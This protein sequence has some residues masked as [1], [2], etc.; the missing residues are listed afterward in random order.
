MYSVLKRLVVGTPL[1]TSEEQHQRLGKPTALAVFASDAISS[2]AYATEE[3]LLVLVPIAGMAALENLIP[4]ALVVTVIL[5]IV[6]TSYR[7]VIHAYPDGGGSYVVSKDNL[8]TTPALVAGAS[9]MVDYVL[10]VAV[11]VSAGTA[12]IVSAFPDLRPHRVTLCLFFV[13]LMTFANLR[14]LKEAGRTFAVPTYVYVVALGC[15]V[16]YGLYRSFFGDLGALPVNQADLEELTEGH[17]VHAASLFLL[18]RAFSSGAVALSGVEAISNGV[19]AFRPPE[20]K[21]AA[22]TLVYMAMILGT[23]FFGIS[24]LAHRLQPTVSEDETLLSIMGAGVFGDGSFL[25]YLLQFSTFGILILAA[26]TAYSGFPLLSSIVA[27]D[28]FLP[29]QLA[30]R[31]DRLVYSNGILVLAG[32]AALLIIVFQGETTLLIPLYAVGVFT[33]FTLSQVGMVRRHV[34]RKE[35]RW[36][37]SVAING[38]GAVATFI[39]LLV[40]VVSKFT[41]GAWIPAVV[42]PAIVV[43]LR[44]VGRHY[45][46]VNEA[47]RPPPNWRP[48]RRTHTVVMPVGRIHAGV[49][50]AIE[51]ARSLA[52]DRLLAVTVASDEEQHEAINAEWRHFDIPVELRVLYSPYRDLTD[53]IMDFLDEISEQNPDDYMTVIVPEF[54]VDHWWEQLLHNQSALALKARLLFRPKTIVVS[55]PFHLG[56]QPAER[57]VDG[58]G[59]R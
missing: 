43:V 21:H 45:D 50:E 25:Y 7:Q 19:P 23:F 55:V 56:R 44:A 15:L 33:G 18:L 2:T 31:G 17:V 47:L 16:G 27:R 9:L 24:V 52:P 57:G 46:R 51:Y 35:P 54:V 26:N 3:I 13:A 36:Q 48:P 30:N 5:A 38:V 14:G 6:A 37:R 49:L 4:I 32:A 34:A 39:V 28:G 11:S 58:R 53:P 20:S 1:A 40:V 42:I 22:Q 8:G 41:I 10:T 59:G 29:R 12:A